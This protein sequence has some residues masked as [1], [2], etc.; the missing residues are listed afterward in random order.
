MVAPVVVTGRHR[1]HEVW[2]LA[3]SAAIG[4]VFVAG[5]RPPSTVEQL[6]PGWV[7]WTWYVLLLASGVAG[8]GSFVLRQPYQ[9]LVLERAAMWGQTIAPALYGLALL[10]FGHTALFAAGFCVAWSGASVWRLVQIRTEIGLLRQ[11]SGEGS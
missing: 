1:P 3:F 7:I 6:M 2:F 8:L 9:A 4:V 10:N 11:A 5:I